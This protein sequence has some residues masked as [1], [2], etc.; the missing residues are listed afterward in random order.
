MATPKISTA[1]N[2]SAVPAPLASAASYTTAN[3]LGSTSARVAN[4][5]PWL[6]AAAV[7][8]SSTALTI[9]LYLSY[10]AFTS[11]KVAGCGGG[12]FDCEH[13]L[14][15]KWS[16]MLGLPVGAWAA[17]LYL[18]VLAALVF[19]ARS[20]TS[21]QSSQLRSWTWTVVTGAAVSA[22]L[23]ALWFTGLQV[24]VLKHFC[25][26]CLGA[27]ACG[28][29]LCIITLLFSPISAQLKGLAAAVGSLGTLG[30]VT[31]Q[32]LTPAPQTFIETQFPTPAQTGPAG[33]LE[34][35]ELLDAPG[36]GVEIL[37][38]PDATDGASLQPRTSN[39]LVAWS[40]AISGLL[41]NPSILL[42]SQV[43]QDNQP[44]NAKPAGAQANN[45]A[46]ADANKESEKPEDRTILLSGANVRLKIN[47][48]PLLGK[49]EAKHVF[50][51][52]F[53][54]TCRHCRATQ[55]AI[56][57]ARKKFGDELAVIV[58]P[59]PLSRA[60]NDTVTNEHASH[61]ESC[62]ISRIAVAVWRV[63]PD[64]FPEFHE[65]L[66]TNEPIPTAALA[67][68]KAAQMVDPTALDK[69]LS[70]P[71]A[72]R[73]IARHVDIYRRMGAGP[74]PKLVFPTTMLTG[75]MTDPAP[76]ISVIER[77]PAK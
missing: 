25:P 36:E 9:S 1:S 32:L 5:L 58:L 50:V 13:V 16:T 71:N 14:N 66:L 68:S 39:E 44:A 7:L 74:V 76:L 53:D 46:G 48:W 35:P 10:V 52:M 42:T 19:T 26:W 15:S 33:T 18:S 27:H 6:L 63:A 20:A 47:Q 43:A 23:A 60:C 54:Y 17:S 62:E 55:K 31:I 40:Y 37:M 56:S 38:A 67:K 34:Q 45:S 57:G 28:M 3:T 24:F 2:P 69:E 21:P 73:Y 22:G 77:Q 8:L 65:W 12:V 41:T 64:K 75:E 61:R 72:G 59:V 51:E 30:L 29:T 70:Q 11:S 49:P 4:R